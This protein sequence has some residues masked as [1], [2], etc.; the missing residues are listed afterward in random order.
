[1]R[2][3]PLKNRRERGNAFIEFALVSMIML[4]LFFG[5]IDYSRVFY[6]ASIVQGAA[7]AGTQYAI[8]QAP[9][10]ANSSAIIAASTADATNVPIAQNFSATPS[11]WCMC[12]NAT[13]PTTISCTS[14]C[15]AGASMYT[16]SQVNTQ[17]T[18]NTMC[19]Y[20]LLPTSI[21]VKGQSIMRVR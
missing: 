5:V 12:S 19:K 20:P 9:N 17:L 10:E 1:M 4:P 8:F 15:G 16:F 13:Y 21:T 18:F 3:I 2:R 6:Y 11:Y 7:R 14:S